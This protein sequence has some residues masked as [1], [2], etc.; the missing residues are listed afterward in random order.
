MEPNREFQAP[1]YDIADGMSSPEDFLFNEKMREDT[2]GKIG[3]LLE[4]PDK[5]T[6]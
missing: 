6:T 3:Q 5:Y 4:R 1:N 2:Q